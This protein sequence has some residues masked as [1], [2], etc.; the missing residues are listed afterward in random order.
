MNLIIGG[1][2][3]EHGRNCFYVESDVNYIIDCGIMRGARTGYPR[4]KAEKIAVAEYL[5][6]T[7]SNE[8]HIGAFS[9]LVAKGFC[10]TV[11]AS[12]ETLASIHGYD[13]CIALP[14]TLSRV[15]LGNAVVRYGRSGHCVGS[16]WFYIKTAGSKA[17]FSGDYCEN[18]RFN[19]DKITNFDAEYA[20]IDCAF[21]NS[22]YSRGAQEMRILEYAEGVLKTGQ[23]LLPVP[24]NGRAVDLI[25][26]LSS[27]DCN[28]SVDEKLYKFFSMLPRDGYWVNKSV[29]KRINDCLYRDCFNHKP[30]VF[31]VA[32]AQLT[33]YEGRRTANNVI[34]S[35]GGILFTG[36]ADKGGEAEKLI[37]CGT[38]KIIP[39]NAHLSKSDADRVAANNNFSRVIY[40]HS[41]DL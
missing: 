26:L 35:G 17:L 12:E 16:L 40:N 30:N 3:H 1:G 23:L 29:I 14:N 20:V 25:Y 24:K 34:K 38:G 6:I 19:V 21:G 37:S 7:H 18:S 2:V 5:F 28:I 9:W 33:S 15:N 39:Y 13:K 8:D 11:V 41:T 10:G 31:L 27:L 32:D 36:H 22:C 4:L